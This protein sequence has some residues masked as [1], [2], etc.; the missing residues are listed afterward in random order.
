MRAQLGIADDAFVFLSFG[1]IRAYKDLE[2]LLAG[3]RPMEDPNARLLIAGLA[4][5]PQTADDVR[6]AACTDT[7]I[8]PLLEFI[9]DERVAELF[10]A[11]D[12]AVFARSDGGTSG[13]LMLALSLGLPVVAADTPL[14]RELVDGGQCG[15]LFRPHDPESLREAMERASEEPVVARLKGG[16][17]RARAESKTWSVA[18]RSTAALMRGDGEILDF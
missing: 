5:D 6:A 11:S 1:H 13:A 3:F 15:W 12:V 9:P 4:I 7:R 2:V 10:E 14:Y 17:A 18:A 16:L 8:K